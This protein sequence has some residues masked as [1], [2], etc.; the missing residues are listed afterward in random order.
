MASANDTTAMMIQA[1]SPE[2]RQPA[3]PA[4]TPTLSPATP[5]MA[6]R[7]RP[8]LVVGRRRRGPVG[9]GGVGLLAFIRCLAAS[10][11][12]PGEQGAGQ[13]DG[14]EWGGGDTVSAVEPGRALYGCHLYDGRV[15]PVEQRRGEGPHIPT[16]EAVLWRVSTRTV[17]FTIW[18]L[19]ALYL[20][21]ELRAVAV[22]VLL[23]VIV[24][25]G[26][27]PIVDR[28]APALDPKPGATRR[29][30]R[31]P[32]AVV[33][34]V[35]YALLLAMLAV[36]AAL[37][38]P[39]AILQIEDLVRNVPNF[40]TPFQDWVVSLPERYPF[41]PAGVVDGLPEQLRGGASQLTG[42]LSQALVVVRLVLGF[43][44]GALNFIFIL[45]LALYLTSDADRV[46][47]YF[48]G[49][50]PLQRRAQAYDVAGRMGD[51]LG[52]WVRGQLMLS[53][54][55]GAITLAGLLAIGVPYAVLLALVAALGEAVPMVGPIFSAVP[56][57]I[58]AFFQSPLQG[59][60]TLGFYIVVQQVE[61]AVVV[62]KVMERAVALHPLAVMLAL[63]IGGELYG[64]TGAILSVPVTAALSVVAAE[65]KRERDERDKQRRLAAG[66]Q[67]QA[68]PGA[69][70]HHHA[71][72]E[73][74]NRD[75]AGPATAGDQ[76]VRAEVGGHAE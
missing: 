24:S 42:F 1:G 71:G 70:P 46:V 49:W 2:M 67:P 10:K 54:I 6:S 13:R 20:L 8:R 16:R 38:V 12:L 39:P 30:R 60:L 63:L 34:V 53:A 58:V 4:S 40:A 17:L 9:L 22:Q 7:R 15:T 19:L 68:D 48:V 76:P 3:A 72:G 21:Y 47:R 36:S 29:R 44:G 5:I 18:V 33:V 69:G 64:V 41:L 37:I 75:S 74:G 51:K 62:P 26:M 59:L 65:I 73:Q 35:L 52:G 11:T 31:A 57:V 14:K 32:R 50:L 27:T 66:D 61:N 55:I 23:A 56:A 43:L 28:I 45:F 25:A